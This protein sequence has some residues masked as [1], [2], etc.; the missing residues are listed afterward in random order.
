M[1]KIQMIRAIH[2][3]AYN[4]ANFFSMKRFNRYTM[5]IKSS[6]TNDTFRYKRGDSNNIVRTDSN[7][8]GSLEWHTDYDYKKQSIYKKQFITSNQSSY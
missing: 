3:D 6:S 1:I 2:I 5:V 8:N 4:S 7:H